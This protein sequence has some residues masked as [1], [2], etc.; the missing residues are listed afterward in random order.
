MYLIHK[1]QLKYLLF[2]LLIVFIGYLLIKKNLNQFLE[3][4]TPKEVNIDDSF[5]LFMKNL[6]ALIKICDVFIC[7]F[8]C[9]KLN[10][11]FNRF[12]KFRDFLFCIVAVTVG[13]IRI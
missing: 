1:T 2:F 11:R 9:K 4:K 12:Q 13:Q 7:Y 5:D 3:F 6:N 10:I 8:E